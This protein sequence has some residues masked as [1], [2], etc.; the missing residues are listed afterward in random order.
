MK[1]FRTCIRYYSLT[2]G[3]LIGT[4]TGCPGRRSELLNLFGFFVDLGSLISIVTKTR[5]GNALRMT[6]GE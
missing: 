3:R 1:D 4:K 2:S 6:Y 5:R